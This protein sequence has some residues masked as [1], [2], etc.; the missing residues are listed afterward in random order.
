MRLL[1]SGIFALFAILGANSV[2]LS[3][4][5]FLEWIKGFRH[6]G[7]GENAA[8]VGLHADELLGAGAEHRHRDGKKEQGETRFHVKRAEGS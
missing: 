5:T 1:L 4:I 8:F 6:D 2:Y 7:L 3:S